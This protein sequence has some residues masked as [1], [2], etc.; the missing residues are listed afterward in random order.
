[1]FSRYRFGFVLVLSGLVSQY[2][3]GLTSQYLDNFRFVEG[4]RRW[5]TSWY[6]LLLNSTLK[7]IDCYHTSYIHSVITPHAQIYTLFSH[8]MFKH[9]L[10]SHNLCT[11]TLCYY[12]HAEIYTF[13][14]HSTLEYN[15]TFLVPQE[16]TKK[17]KCE[18]ISGKY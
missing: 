11:Y 8:S 16:I 6:T 15:F 18:M 4:L 17:R 3:F 2:W 5:S 10:L 9:A 13:L 12:T 7:Y 14:S 1:M